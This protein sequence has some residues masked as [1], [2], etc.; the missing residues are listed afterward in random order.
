M[1]AEL[2]YLHRFAVV[3]SVDHPVPLAYE[4]FRSQAE[5]VLG[6]DVRL[7]VTQAVEAMKRARAGF[8]VGN[9]A[10]PATTSER[11]TFGSHSAAVLATQRDDGRALAATALATSLNMMK[12]PAALPAPQTAT[13]HI[14]F[15]SHAAYCVVRLES[16]PAAAAA[17]TQSK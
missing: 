15:P 11:V 13:M 5:T 12:W 4:S 14:T 2:T 3:H 17:A 9:K 7:L 8:E 6:G 1:N 16:P 10:L